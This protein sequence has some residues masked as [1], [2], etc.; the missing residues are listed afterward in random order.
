MARRSSVRKRS[1]NRVLYKYPEIYTSS[2][3]F[4]HSMSLVNRPSPADL[5]CII[6]QRGLDYWRGE[7]MTLQLLRYTNWIDMDGIK[8]IQS[9]WLVEQYVSTSFLSYSIL[10]FMNVTTFCVN[11]YHW[12]QVNVTYNYTSTCLLFI[13]SLVNQALLLY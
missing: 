3:R 2:K 5:Q 13:L 8:K 11:V 1:G 12:N 10:H 6:F 4:E 9:S 7:Y